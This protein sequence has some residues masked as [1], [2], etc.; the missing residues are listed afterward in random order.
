MSARMLRKKPN[1]QPLVSTYKLRIVWTCIEWANQVADISAPK[2]CFRELEYGDAYTDFPENYERIGLAHTVRS[3]AIENPMVP[4]KTWKP[5]LRGGRILVMA[6]SETLF[7]G[8]AEI[9]TGGFFDVSNYPPPG[10]WFD[11]VR[12]NFGLQNDILSYVPASFVELVERGIA[13]NAEECIR[14]LEG[15][16]NPNLDV[17]KKLF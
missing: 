14:W 9:E 3:N 6:P 8:I 4:F 10:L 2:T 17:Y 13:C 11:Q 16:N 1:K 12:S 5:D 15:D 7:D